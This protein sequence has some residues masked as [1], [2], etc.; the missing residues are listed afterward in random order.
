MDNDKRARVWWLRR[1]PV[2]LIVRAWKCYARRQWS[3]SR[4]RSSPN[5]TA[6][7]SRKRCGGAADAHRG[8]PQRPVLH[9]ESSSGGAAHECCIGTRRRSRRPVRRERGGPGGLSDLDEPEVHLGPRPDKLVPD[10]AGWRRERWLG[11]PDRV[12]ITVIPDWICEVLSP[13]TE[14]V[15]RGEKVA[16]YARENIAFA[17]LIDASQQTVEVYKLNGGR[18]GALATLRGNTVV[19][20]EHFDAIEIDLAALWTI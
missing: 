11:G 5:P 10:L 16:I 4:N 14:V 17:W 9:A 13:S 20:A 12:G 2:G 18:W 3:P 8:D 6:P 7:R 1:V 19:R 15:D